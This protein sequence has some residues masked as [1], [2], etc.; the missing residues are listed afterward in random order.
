MTNIYRFAETISCH[1]WNAD[2][3]KIA[4]CPN[5]NTILIYAKDGNDW[6]LEHT[7]DEHTQIVTGLDW[8]KKQNRILS[9]SQDRNAYVWTLDTKANEWKPTL[10]ILR[11]NRCATNV[12]WSPNEDKFAVG[13]GAKV[14]S[15]CYFEESNDW[16]VSKH[17][18][19]HK[20]TILSVKWHPN[21]VLVATASSDYKCRV[22]SAWTKGVDKKGV[23]APGS[24]PSGELE[25]FGT[26]LAEYQCNSWV[27]DCAFSPSG[28]SLVFVGQDS[29][30]S[31]VDLA[32]GNV[33]TLRLGTLPFTR[34]IF[35]TEDSA[36]AVG[37]D[38]EPILFKNSGGWKKEKSLDQ[39]ETNTQKKGNIASM[40]KT[41]DTK[42]TNQ[43]V[44]TTLQTKHQNT[45][46]WIYQQGKGAF[47]TSG[48]DGNVV[49]WKY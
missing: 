47:T 4:L 44:E 12:E 10:V 24:L 11:L 35:P 8:G 17:I 27:K 39:K 36:I 1:A 18:K 30:F 7:L 22:I 38:C 33:S 43:A 45:I 37:F 5:D 25:K 34:C 16:W 31:V 29:S 6:K 20:S 9:C 14:V 21:N 19:K 3:T 48:L 28:N 13:T 46:T 15:I 42:G 41:M 2:G 49:W 26:I 23:T 32:S 40:W